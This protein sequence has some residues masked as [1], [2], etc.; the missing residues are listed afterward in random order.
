MPYHT[1][2]D[3][4]C[5]PGTDVLKNKAGH[6]NQDRLDA[7][8]T[9][10]SAQRATEPLPLGR[11]SVTHYRAIHQ[12]LFQDVYPWAGKFRTVRISKGSSTFCY[13]E[14]IPN[15]MSALFKELKGIHCLVGL[16]TAVFAK[17]TAIFLSTLNAIHPFRDG[18][19][20][21]QLT[22]IA[23]L[24]ESAGHSFEFDQ[25]DPEEYLRASIQSFN[26][27]SRELEELLFKLCS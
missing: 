12:H 11:F 5:Y 3:P 22:F 25:L 17:K 19:G 4:Y 23:L 9:V 7:F 18:N 14:H 21:A 1:E 8:E 13:P 15:Q 26:G 24:G 2:A 6:R 16:P 20:R 27:N 10:M